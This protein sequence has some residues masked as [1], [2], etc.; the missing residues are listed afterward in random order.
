MEKIFNNKR[1]IFVGPS[2]E[3]VNNGDYFGKF[4]DDFDVIIRSNGALKLIKTHPNIFGTKTDVMFLNDPFM[5]APEFNVLDYN[6]IPY[7]YT[8]KKINPNY[9]GKNIII[10]MIELEKKMKNVIKVNESIRPFGGMFIVAEV[11]KYNPFEFFVVGVSNYSKNQHHFSN[12]LPSTIKPENVIKRQKLYHIK[13]NEYQ[14]LYFRE[15]LKNNIIKMDKYSMK[16]F[17]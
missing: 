7:I 16:N 11:L 1:V 9:S 3:I 14:K 10:N 15:L 12:Y 6:N 2:P 13:T 8:Y 5:D 17:I 4:I